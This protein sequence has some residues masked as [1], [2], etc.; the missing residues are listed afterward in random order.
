MPDM[1]LA[2][3]FNRAAEI[4]EHLKA[5]GFTEGPATRQTLALAE[6]VGEFTDKLTIIFS[7][8]WREPTNA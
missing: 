8:G 3:L 4:E 7:R 1:S 2:D 5:A 6:E